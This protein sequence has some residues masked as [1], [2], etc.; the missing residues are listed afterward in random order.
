MYVADVLTDLAS[1][2]GTAQH[3]GEE[4]NGVSSKNT[5][6]QNIAALNS[7]IGDVSELKDATYAQGDTLVESIQNVDNK[8]VNLDTRMER[9]E[10][11]LK[12]VHH[13]LRR[14]MASMAAMS[15]LVP[16]SRSTGK[17]SLSVGTGAYS[18]HGAVAVGG[19]HYLTDN[20][21][22]NA[23]AAWSNSR[24]AVYRVGLTY[25]F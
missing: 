7:V 24:D 3:L 11:D 22:F 9:A 20:L 8:L 4:K 15:A 19:F 1:Q 6:N 12:D 23:G 25:S 21:M 16:N 18:G 5:V 10:R 14:G 13:E 2:I 17:T